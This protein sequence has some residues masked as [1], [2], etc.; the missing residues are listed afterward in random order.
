M[1]PFFLQL[2]QTVVR[3]QSVKRPLWN[4]PC[5]LFCLAVTGVTRCNFFCNLSRNVGKR[6][7]LQVAED[8]L[9]GAT[10]TAT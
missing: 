4:L 10:R 6:N 2:R 7:L 3:L 1:I 8:I 5:N 9:Q